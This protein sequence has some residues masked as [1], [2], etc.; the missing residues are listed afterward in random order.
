MKQSHYITPRT[1]EEAEFQPWGEA[2]HY[3]TPDHDCADLIVMWASIAA[4]L[5]L[6]T[7]ALMGWLA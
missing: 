7:L 6:G 1:M 2:F 5:A 3:T 4:M